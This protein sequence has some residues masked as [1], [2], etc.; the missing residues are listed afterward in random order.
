MLSRIKKISSFLLIGLFSL[1]S[2]N[3]M[4]VKESD[5]IDNQTFNKKVSE[6]IL[7]NPEIIVEALENYKNNT[8]QILQKKINSYIT[9]NLKE[10]ED[11]KS[12][13]YF[14][15][16]DGDI[17]IVMFFDYSCGYCKKAND[18]INQLLLI[19]KDIKL[20]YRPYAVLGER[21]DYIT[22]IILS[23]YLKNPESFKEFHDKFMG[24]VQLSENAI[25]EILKK[26]NINTSSTDN[27][28]S[29]IQQN[30]VSLARE[31]YISGVPT[32]IINGNIYR[33]MLSLNDLTKIID[34]LRSENK[35]FAKN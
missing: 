2:Q 25:N 28:L 7:N 22:K 14:G 15:N 33:G 1:A 35:E 20:V 31:L 29:S 26:Y 9:N 27:K 6:F 32:F 8:A 10:I 13:P 23:I 16:I 24:T 17:S 3:S 21:S 11:V 5:I 4:S 18:I 34:K 12:N 19:D 30:T